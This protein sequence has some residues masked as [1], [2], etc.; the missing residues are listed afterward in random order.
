MSSPPQ[1]SATV[2]RGRSPFFVKEDDPTLPFFLSSTSALDLEFTCNWSS[3]YL[4]YSSTLSISLCISVI[5]IKVSKVLNSESIASP[6]LKVL[7]ATPPLFPPILLYNS[8]YQSEYALR[9][10]PSFM[11]IEINESKGFGILLHVTN[12]ALNARVSSS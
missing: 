3:S 10:S 2:F 1:I 7:A 6:T 11:D 8:Q 12:L 5:G 9:V 4:L